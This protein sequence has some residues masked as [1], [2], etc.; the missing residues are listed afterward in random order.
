M[1]VRMSETSGLMKAGNFT[2]RCPIANPGLRRAS[3]D[4]R[5][6]PQGGGNEIVK[7]M[8][9]SLMQSW[10]YYGVPAA[11]QDAAAEVKWQ[12]P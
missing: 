10:S 1:C 5:A 2:R 11:H 6:V 7:P 3:F 9:V 8:W 4:R 12:S